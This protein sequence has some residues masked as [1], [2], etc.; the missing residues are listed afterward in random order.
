MA[1]GDKLTVDS[2]VVGDVI[3]ITGTS[4]GRGFA[5]VVKRHGFAG[6]PASHGHKDQLRMPGSIGA[7]DPGR[8][9]KGMRMGG[10]MGD[11]QVTTKGLTIEKVDRE[12]NV[13]FVRGSVPGA[14][15]GFVFLRGAGDMTVEKTDEPKKEEVVQAETEQDASDTKA[16]STIGTNDKKQPTDGNA[17]KVVEQE[18]SKED[19]TKEPVNA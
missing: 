17:S 14:I 9:F 12:N 19:S 6:S 11:R 2:F 13:L 8:V 18:E 16:D 7:T 1:V 3:D 10:H 15:N 5:G 4:K